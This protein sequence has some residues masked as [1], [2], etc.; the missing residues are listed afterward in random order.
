MPQWSLGLAVLA[1]SGALAWLAFSRRSP[2]AKSTV[3]LVLSLSVAAFV[4]LSLYFYQF[5]VDDTY[6]SLRYARNLANGYGLVFSTDGSPPV[7]GYTNFLW[8]MLETPL[9]LLHLPT[10]LVL[11]AVKVIGIAF[12]IG[13]IITTF[14]LLQL[15]ISEVWLSLLGAALFSGVPYLAFWAVGGLETNMYLFF[16]LLGLYAYLLERRRNQ[17]HIRSTLCFLLMALTRPEGLFFVGAVAVWELGARR[18]VPHENQS[19]RA[20]TIA[21]LMAGLGLFAVLYGAYFLWR[22]RFYGFLLPNTFYARSGAWGIHQILHRAREMSPFLAYLLP[23]AAV[24]C[25]GAS[26]WTEQRRREGTLLAVVLVLLVGFGFLPKREW[27]PGFRYELPFVP[28]LILFVAAGLRRMPWG[29]QSERWSAHLPRLGALLSLGA[30]LLYP[31]LGLHSETRYT[32]R[33]T[34]AHVALGKWLHQN[35]PSGASYASFD[36]G[37]VPYYSELPRIIDTNLE[38]ILSTYT[39][40]RGFDPAQMLALQPSFLVLPPR[41][42]PDRVAGIYAFYA[43]ARL[44]Q[45]YEL[46]FSLAFTR[47]YVLDVYRLRNVPLSPGALEEA[48]ALERESFRQASLDTP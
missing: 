16:L 33:L 41:P 7:E 34:R 30:Y 44:K 1:L 22:Y 35:A 39:T 31:A 3:V 18:L 38:G 21:P 26:Y 25:M 20:N 42:G 48:K 5:T 12:G 10:E 36:M 8:V 40:H 23:L 4:A 43:N 24:A 11:H 6:I 37:A 46:I 13:V 17:P 47:D 29:E 45:D 14:F 27:M 2:V 32:D 15:V 9:L 28:V 19:N